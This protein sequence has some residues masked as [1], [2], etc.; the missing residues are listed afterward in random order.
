MYCTK[1]GRELP[2]NARF[3][4]NCAEPVPMTRGGQAVVSNDGP[5][6]T[7]PAPTLYDYKLMQAQSQNLGMKWY[8]F[9]IYVQCFLGGIL[10][11]IMGLQ[12]A[13]GLQYGKN[14]AQVYAYYPRL[15]AVDMVYGVAVILLG[16]ALLITRFGLKK[17]KANAA[18][19]YIFYP[20]V[21]LGISVAYYV[22]ISVLL[23]SGVVTESIGEFAPTMF[24]NI[25]L[26]IANYKYF[27]NRKHLFSE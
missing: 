21:A 9:I 13:T 11:V 8:K 20:L 16:I 27:G 3:C 12:I 4:G 14:A 6:L 25:V 23:G 24:G 15:R 19:M 7:S 1:C 22:A 10:N 18:T 2:P 5:V 17:F 26:F